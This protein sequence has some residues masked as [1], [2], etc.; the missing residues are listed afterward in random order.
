MNQLPPD[1]LKSLQMAHEKFS[2]LP[3]QLSSFSFNPYETQSHQGYQPTMNETPFSESQILEDLKRIQSGLTSNEQQ[4]QGSSTPTTIK[5]HQEQQ[6]GSSGTTS[7][8]TQGALYNIPRQ[9]TPVPEAK[10]S[11][12]KLR[13]E[14]IL[15]NLSSSNISPSSPTYDVSGSYQNQNQTNTPVPSPSTPQPTNSSQSPSS[16]LQKYAPPHQVPVAS[17]PFMFGPLDKQNHVYSTFPLD[18]NQER[19]KVTAI[20]GIT[21]YAC[22][23]IFSN[24]KNIGVLGDFLAWTL[25]GGPIRVF[26]RKTGARCLLKGHKQ[27]VSDLQCGTNLKLATASRDRSLIVWQVIDTEDKT[28]E[29]D[30]RNPK[31]DQFGYTKI[32]HLAFPSSESHRFFKRILWAPESDSELCAI[33]NDNQ[34]FMLDIEK[35][36]DLNEEIIELD[37]ENIESIDG[38][39]ILSDDLDE[40]ESLTDMSFSSD[41]KY[42]ACVSSFG[43][44]YVWDRR[45]NMTLVKQTNIYNSE[46]LNI[47]FFSG[48]E[49]NVE[50]YFVTSS[51]NNFDI[52]LWYLSPELDIELIQQMSIRPQ[53]WEESNSINTITLDPTST[54]LC[55]A[56]LHNAVLFVLRLNKTGLIEQTGHPYFDCIT[57]F[58]SK[59]PIVNAVCM[60]IGSTFGLFALQSTGSHLL[61]IKSSQVSPPVQETKPPIPMPDLV[62]PTSAAK[63]LVPVS[64]NTGV[65]LRQPIVV[66]G[67]NNTTSGGSIPT[68]TP[69]PSSSTAGVSSSNFEILSELRRMERNL[70]NQMESMIQTQTERQYDQLYKRI[71]QERV[72]RLTEERKR[73]KE[74]IE[75]ISAT[76]SNDLPNEIANSVTENVV[77]DLG[78]TLPY[79][80]NDA[81][82]QSLTDTSDEGSIKKTIQDSFQTVLKTTVLPS[83]ETSCRRM[84]EQIS[85]TFERGMDELVKNPLKEYCRDINETTVETIKQELKN[86]SQQVSKSSDPS[87]LGDAALKEKLL[88]LIE[89][90]R[91]QEAFTIVLEKTDLNLLVWICT[92]IDPCIFEVECPFSQP[93]LLAL[94][95]QLG[96]DIT[97]QTFVK[98]A[99]LE[100][101]VVHINP[102]DSSIIENAHT[103]IEKIHA[104]VADKYE[105]IEERGKAIDLKTLKLVLHVLNSLLKDSR[106]AKKLYC[107]K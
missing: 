44:I 72:A 82:K 2:T 54:V 7:P 71:E 3:P 32:V 80:M 51:Q 65:A 105:D 107:N 77:G 38:I 73:Q 47:Q 67:T 74:L 17:D 23:L 92:I 76:L 90:H 39:R 15:N 83:F 31:E 85:K 70:L 50:R 81:L 37:S 64:T 106:D 42:L 1:L 58:D 57:E 18:S 48:T 63:E 99:W 19:K 95:Q 14:K 29:N 52:S 88:T 27:F 55:V 13:S 11:N 68:S 100:K 101:I 102:L 97:E 87:N 104:C 78:N 60:T 96:Y 34:L 21:N 33:T 91:Y 93:V 4:Q 8:H 35:L 12:T 53:K 40:N 94:V 16:A 59:Y 25:K 61:S 28:Q 45:T 43:N 9:D 62:H 79:L 5:T 66:N 24:G 89:L 84:F 75:T 20:K 46:L 10:P 6:Q 69:S 103:I 86:F 26:N 98:L 30:L 36:S 22:D 56:N 41:G 49:R